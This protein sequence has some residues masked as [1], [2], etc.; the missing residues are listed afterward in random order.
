V[1]TP[2]GTRCNLGATV[3]VS[4]VNPIGGDAACGA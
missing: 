3:G 1:P 2:N 4:L